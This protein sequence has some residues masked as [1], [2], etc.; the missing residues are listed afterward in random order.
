M[1]AAQ[2]TDS[3]LPVAS[4]EIEA[5][6]PSGTQSTEN[7][8]KFWAG[9]EV[10]KVWGFWTIERISDVGEVVANVLGLNNSKFQYVI[11]SMSEEDWKI[12]RAVQAQR[13]EQQRN[14]E[15][16]VAAMEGGAVVQ[17]EKKVVQE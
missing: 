11:D 5:E 3:N 9:W 2:E 17:T 8:D 7:A 6:V 12:A 13:E 15:D 1:S 4:T 14:R 10:V 16:G